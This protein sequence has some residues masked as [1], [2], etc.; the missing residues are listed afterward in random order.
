[1]ATTVISCTEPSPVSNSNLVFI[2]ES[3]ATTATGRF[4]SAMAVLG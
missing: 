4:V 2:R 3:I 1:N